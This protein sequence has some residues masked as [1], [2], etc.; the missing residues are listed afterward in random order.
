MKTIRFQVTQL[1]EMWKAQTGA[2]VNVTV[3]IS[4]VVEKGKAADGLYDAFWI[5]PI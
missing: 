3:F 2:L 1:L 5:V 4:I